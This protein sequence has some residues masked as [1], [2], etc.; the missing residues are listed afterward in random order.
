MH[1]RHPGKKNVE[2]SKMLGEIWRYVPL[3]LLSGLTVYM[4]GLTMYI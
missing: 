3:R 2:I 4:S 1:K